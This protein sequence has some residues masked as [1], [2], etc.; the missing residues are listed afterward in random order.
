[1]GKNII[2]CIL[3]YKI[4]CK[5]NTSNSDLFLNITGQDA[6]GGN[7]TTESSV[8]FMEIAG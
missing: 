4:T 7:F 1:M 8:T 2:T 6:S 5:G 3:T